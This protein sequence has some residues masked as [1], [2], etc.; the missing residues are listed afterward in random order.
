MS[1]STVD[2]TEE[3]HLTEKILDVVTDGLEGQNNGK[4]CAS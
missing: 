4:C 1:K 3:R 2:F